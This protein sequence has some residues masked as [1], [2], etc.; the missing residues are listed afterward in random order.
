MLLE[1]GSIHGGMGRSRDGGLAVGGQR[2][3]FEQRDCN[4]LTVH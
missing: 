3:L 2:V 4:L 1:Y